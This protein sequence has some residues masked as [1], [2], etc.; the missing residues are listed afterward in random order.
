MYS[1]LN[2]PCERMRWEGWKP[3]A[4]I[5]WLCTVGYYSMFQ[6]NVLNFPWKS[7]I[8]NLFSNHSLAIN[9]FQYFEV[10]VSSN[11]F[12]LEYWVTYFIARQLGTRCLSN[13]TTY[14]KREKKIEQTE[15]NLNRM[16]KFTARVV[17]VIH[18]C[19]QVAIAYLFLF[20][21]VIDIFFTSILTFFKSQAHRI[22]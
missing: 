4:S 15:N 6:S 3:S 2:T 8:T 22:S 13:C 11:R 7:V 10:W 19:Q 20:N 12:S 16:P 14:K 1:K 5:L 21:L 18:F 9:C 17:V